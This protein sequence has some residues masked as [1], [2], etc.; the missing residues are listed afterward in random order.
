[1]SRQIYAVDSL[2]GGGPDYTETFRLILTYLFLTFKPAP[3][4]MFLNF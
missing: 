2:P 4:I 1:M 3:I